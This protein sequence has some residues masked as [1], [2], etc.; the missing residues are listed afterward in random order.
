MLYNHPE[1]TAEVK[2]ILEGSVGDYLTEV[3]DAEPISGSEDFSY[4]LL[5]TPGTFIN[6][7]AR[8]VGMEDP[9]PNHHPKFEINEDALFICA[10]G[11]GDVVLSRLEA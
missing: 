7:G 5:K 6:V 3:A 8:P 10:K 1:E 11:L 9:Y 2:R 4:Y